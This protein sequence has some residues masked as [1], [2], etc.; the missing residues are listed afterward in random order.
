MT[1]LSCNFDSK[2]FIYFYKDFKVGSFKHHGIKNQLQIMQ[3]PFWNEL[4]T[5]S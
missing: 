5:I 4:G 1:K 3:S 2:F